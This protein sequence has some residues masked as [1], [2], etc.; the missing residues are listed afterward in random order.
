MSFIENVYEHDRMACDKIPYIA[1]GS[2]LGGFI[3]FQGDQGEIQDRE[4]LTRI[5]YLLSIANETYDKETKSLLWSLIVK[6]RH[7]WRMVILVGKY[8][9][10]RFA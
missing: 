5:K 6:M 10:I 7:L 9:F 1:I 3:V 8:Q 4:R 2:N